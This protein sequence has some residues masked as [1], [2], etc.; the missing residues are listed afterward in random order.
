MNTRRASTFSLG[1]QSVGNGHNAVNLVGHTVE[2]HGH[3]GLVGL[4]YVT[5]LAKVENLSDGHIM[6]EWRQTGRDI[7]EGQN[8]EGCLRG[9]APE[10]D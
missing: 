6:M 1:W 8:R 10:I 3:D 9:P 4:L 2:R 5:M 7:T